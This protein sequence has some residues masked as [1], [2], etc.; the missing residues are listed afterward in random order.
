MITINRDTSAGLKDRR[1][2]LANPAGSASRNRTKKEM[3]IIADTLRF[4]CLQVEDRTGEFPD[5]CSM[6][7]GES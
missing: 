5:E 2:Y 4:C 3:A 1:Y 6:D 7:K